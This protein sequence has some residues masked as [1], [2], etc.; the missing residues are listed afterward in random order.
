MQE[1]NS[2]QE[3]DMVSLVSDLSFQ[4]KVAERCAKSRQ[5]VYAGMQP[6]LDQREDRLFSRVELTQGE[7][8][9]EFRGLQEEFYG[10]LKE[11][12]QK[13]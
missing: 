10:K 7:C 4:V 3:A 6:S 12:L 13:P 1:Q 2:P 8:L 9:D 5:L 11:H